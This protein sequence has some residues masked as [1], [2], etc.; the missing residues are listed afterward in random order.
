ML[1]FSQVTATI[2]ETP[3]TQLAGIKHSVCVSIQMLYFSG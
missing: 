1:T 3:G 2:S